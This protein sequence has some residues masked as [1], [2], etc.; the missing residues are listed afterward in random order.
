MTVSSD[1]AIAPEA[2]LGAVVLSAGGIG[3]TRGELRRWAERFDPAFSGRAAYRAALG[4][5]ELDDDEAFD[6]RVEEAAADFR[7]ARSLEAADELTAWLAARGLTV[8]AWWESVR[9]TTLETKFRDQPLLRPATD[10]DADADGDRPPV[11]PDADVALADLVVTDLLDDARRALAR[12]IAVACDARALPATTDE[13]LRHDALEATWRPW[14]A[15]LLQEA[16]L[17]D[18]VQHERLSWL[19]VETTESVW[20]SADAANEAISCV[21]ADGM[22]LAEVAD[23]AGVEARQL[24]RLLADAPDTLR[25]ALLTTAPGELIGPLARDGQWLVV[26]LHA[27]SAPTLD[28]PLVREAAARRLEERATAALVAQHVTFVDARS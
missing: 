7:Y 14:R 6:A 10:D 26:H 9:R 3:V 4:A 18:V 5:I 15:A 16:A 1:P 23:E 17:Q 27:K 25:D 12:R 28:E 22:A 19:M 24:R 8:D 13:A 20:P 21:Q 2:V 11:D